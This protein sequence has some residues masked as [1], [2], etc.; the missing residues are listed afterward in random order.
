MKKHAKAL[1]GLLKQHFGTQKQIRGA[2]V[3][4]W[5]GE[6]SRDLLVAFPRL[7][8][9]M[10][11]PWEKLLEGTPTMPKALEEVKAAR[12]QATKST[13]YNK[14]II[15]QHTSINA[16][17]Q[18]MLQQIKLDFV[19]IDACHMYESVRDDI[20]AWASLVKQNGIICGHDYNGVGDRRCG[21]GVKRAVDEAFGDKVQVL[22]G[23][24]WFVVKCL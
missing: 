5:Q 16:A 11:D 24:V 21:W 7:T 3:G 1:V 14:R 22:P 2:E 17:S 8:L 19:F 18:L 12:A 15:V 20:Q 23:N 9:W 4:V 10:V 6:L 13:Q